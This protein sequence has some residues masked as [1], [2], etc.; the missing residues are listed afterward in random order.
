MNA[1]LKIPADS[2]HA[3]VHDAV[4]SGFVEVLGIDEPDEHDDFF[5]LG[6]DSLMALSLFLHIEERVGETL[7]ITAIYDAPTIA[8]LTERLLNGAAPA[9]RTNLVELRAASGRRPGAPLFLLHGMGGSVMVLRGLAR[10]IGGERAVWG[11]EA[12]GMDGQTTPHGSV[13]E[14][15]DAAVQEIRSVAP[16]GPYLL[17]GYSFGG[18]VALEVARRLAAA[19]EEVAL[20]AMLDTFPHPLTWPIGCRARAIWRQVHVYASAKVWARL[21]RR[22]FGKVRGRTP[23]AAFVQLC[24][25]A[26]RAVTIPMDIMG[27]A[28]VYDLAGR[29][30]KPAE[31]LAPPDRNATTTA[32]YEAIE[33]VTN[34]ARRAFRSYKPT[35]YDGALL[36][37]HATEQQVVPF[38]PQG[39]WGHL[40]GRLQVIDVATDHQA[41]VRGE[42]RGTAAKL[43]AAID[44]ALARSP[45]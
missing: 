26:V 8:K 1:I 39:V 27:T 40:V 34:A 33:R 23:W 9:R 28:W 12:E 36:V 31:L 20:L 15:A 4:R 10:A 38:E 32:S 14:M 42:A 3:T 44:A 19:G 7:P 30:P 6:G 11:V 22:A 21:I 18:L 17:A 37:V 24:R 29:A 25:G 13:E 16:Q 5:E 45:K 41:L 2:R 35:P 43:T